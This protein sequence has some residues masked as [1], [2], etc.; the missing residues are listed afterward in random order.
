MST[1]A[2][3]A[4]F[5]RRLGEI[6]ANAREIGMNWTSVCRAVGVSRANPDRWRQRIPKTI[7]VVRQLEDVVAEARKQHDNA[8]L[9]AA[10]LAGQE[11]AAAE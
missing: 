1:E 6:E 10:S 4:L 3:D 8:L 2:F 5:K 9:A 7:R 11:S